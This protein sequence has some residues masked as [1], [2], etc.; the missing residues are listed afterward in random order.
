MSVT[1][2]DNWEYARWVYIVGRSLRVNPPARPGAE[3]TA[4]T[5]FIT[6]ELAKRPWLVQQSWEKGNNTG[7]QDDSTY[8]GEMIA[9]IGKDMN[10]IPLIDNDEK[11]ECD[12]LFG[13]TD[14]RR[15]GEQGGP[16]GADVEW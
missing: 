10:K 12:T 13:S 3:Y 9:V 15:Y 4:A 5:T 8:V 11:T 7:G 14:E 1:T 16:A 6:N 2:V